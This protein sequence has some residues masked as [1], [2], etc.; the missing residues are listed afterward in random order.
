MEHLCLCDKSNSEVLD[1][2]VNQKRELNILKEEVT[3]LKVEIYDLKQNVR[4]KENDLKTIR[5][6]GAKSCK[7]LLMKIKC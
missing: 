5:E 6:R 7:N 2:G 4:I 3:K 1:N